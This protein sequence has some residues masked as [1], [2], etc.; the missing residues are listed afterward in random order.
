M[1]GSGPTPST[2]AEGETDAHHPDTDNADVRTYTVTVT[3][4]PAADNS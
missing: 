1:T 2:P 4:P 3:V